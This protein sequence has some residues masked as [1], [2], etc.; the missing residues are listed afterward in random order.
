[1]AE[2]VPEFISLMR[3]IRDVYYK[4]LS[5]GLQIIKTVTPAFGRFSEQ[6]SN[7]DANATTLDAGSDA[8]VD[9]DLTNDQQMIFNFGIPRGNDGSQGPAGPEGPQGPAGVGIDIKGQ[10]TCTD[11]L[12]KDAGEVG[13]SWI[14]TTDGCTDADGVAI[15]IDDVVRAR[16]AGAGTTEW[17]TIG[18]IVGPAGPTGPQGPEGPQGPQG[19]KG[20]K[21]DEGSQIHFYQNVTTPPIEPGQN[22]G[23]MAIIENQD[24]A[25]DG[26]YFE[27][28]D[29]SGSATWTERGKLEGPTG[30][31]GSYWLTGNGAP[32][33][34]P[35]AKNLDIYLDLDTNDIYQLINGTWELKGNIGGDMMPIGSIIMFNG[36]FSDIPSNWALCDGSNGTP[37]LVGQFIIG[38]A[39]EADLGDTGGSADAV[40]VEHSHGITDN[41]HTH[42]VEYLSNPL[43]SDSGGAH[44]SVLNYSPDEQVATTSATTGIT[45][46]SE[47]ISGT[48]ANLPPYYT[49]AYI[50][51]ISNIF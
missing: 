39:T 44:N 18:P 23:D 13:E 28:I 49:L 12:A 38:T 16:V 29:V 50:M 45:I 48:D 35:G 25:Y 51:K 14:A 47:G 34:V 17:I 36:S 32:T 40:V 7:P 24:E 22:I 1:M 5:N 8:T 21:G 26:L 41:G 20:D 9:L 3:T 46:N 10:E 6:I 37:D 11:I 2:R 19:P 31:R 15:E 43:N 42:D 4:E 30:E 33:S 27:L